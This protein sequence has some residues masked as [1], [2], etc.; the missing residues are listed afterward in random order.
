MLH[1]LQNIVDQR[2]IDQAVPLAVGRLDDLTVTKDDGAPV[3][4]MDDDPVAVAAG[5]TGDLAAVA[6][7]V[8]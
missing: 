8:I 3:R 7:S 2:L 5:L 1:Q 6:G 4:Q